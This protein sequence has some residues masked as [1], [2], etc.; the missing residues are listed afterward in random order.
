MLAGNCFLLNVN[1]TGKQCPAQAEVCHPP[2]SQHNPTILTPF[3]GLGTTICNQAVTGPS[4]STH[5][6]QDHPAIQKCTTCYITT[7]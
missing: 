7:M 1:V 2:P 4:I 5:C 6:I 3:A